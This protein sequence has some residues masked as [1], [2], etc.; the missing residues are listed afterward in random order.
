MDEIF[1]KYKDKFQEVFGVSLEKYWSKFGFEIL[2][3]ED[4]VIKPSSF[5]SMKDRLLARWGKEAAQLIWEILGNTD[6]LENI[7]ETKC[8]EYEIVSNQV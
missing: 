4:E 7:C 3:F 5:Q 6:N 2:K 8:S 1:E